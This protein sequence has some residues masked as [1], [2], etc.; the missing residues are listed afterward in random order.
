[1]SLEELNQWI[2]YG[3]SDSDSNTD[4]HESYKVTKTGQ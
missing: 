2:E 1:M 3:D 4:E